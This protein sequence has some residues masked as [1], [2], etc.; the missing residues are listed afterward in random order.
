LTITQLD[1]ESAVPLPKSAPRVRYAHA[2]GFAV[3]AASATA[4]SGVNKLAIASLIC[5]LAGIPLFGLITGLVAVVLGVLALSAIRASAQR[6]LGLA[7]AGL[8]LGIVDM[9]GSIIILGIV[10][11]QRGPDLH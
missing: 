3:G 11:T 9:T 1:L 6:G 2:T 7:L 5:G 8:I 10:L 4:P